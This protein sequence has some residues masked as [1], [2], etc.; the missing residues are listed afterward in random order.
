MAMGITSGTR[1]DKFLGYMQS[2]RSAV[3]EGQQD[4]HLDPGLSQKDELKLIDKDIKT[5]QKAPIL[6]SQ[7]RDSVQNLQEGAAY[8]KGDMA[9]AGLRGAFGPPSYSQGGQALDNSVHTSMVDDIAG[10]STA[11]GVAA[12]GGLA[13]A[14]LSGV[15]NL[16]D[17]RKGDKL[18]ATIQRWES[19]TAQ[20]GSL[21]HF[22]L[23][24]QDALAHA[25]SQVECHIAK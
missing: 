14:G 4:V 25:S 21:S 11:G 23:E 19:A 15:F 12:A 1:V 2:V 13:S 7:Q 16:L 9:H 18:D 17:H 20:G 6:V 8:L 10:C 22:S 5:I 3:A 24:E